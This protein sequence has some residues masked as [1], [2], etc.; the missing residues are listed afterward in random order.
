M[1]AII[2]ITEVDLVQIE[3]VA[4]K[5]KSLLGIFSWWVKVSAKKLRDDIYITTNRDIENVYLN[6]KLFSSTS[7]KE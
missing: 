2:S 5:K 6:G 7:I 1:N 3:K 4:Y